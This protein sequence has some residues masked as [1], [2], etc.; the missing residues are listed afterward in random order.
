M[1]PL[2]PNQRLQLLA[3]L[4]A[5]AVSRGASQPAHALAMGNALVIFK[6]RDLGL[7]DSKTVHRL[8]RQ[9]TEYWLTPSGV[10]RARGLKLQAA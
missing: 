1:R 6:L 3:L 7:A 9:W 2:T 8:G 10:E 5:G 4:D